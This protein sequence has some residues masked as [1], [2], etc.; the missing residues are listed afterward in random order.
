MT[1]RT[2]KPKRAVAP[3]ILIPAALFLLPLVP[4]LAYFL[5]S[6]LGDFY[7][8]TAVDHRI[9]YFAAVGQNFSFFRTMFDGVDWYR[10]ITLDARSA[11]PELPSLVI[12]GLVVMALSLPIFLLSRHARRPGRYAV[13]CIVLGMV[14]FALFP[15]FR[16]LNRP[17][18]F[19]VLTPIFT[20]CCITATVSFLSFCA[21]RFKRYATILRIS[22]SIGLTLILVVSVRHGIGLL[23]RIES[24]KGAC[25]T[26]M[27]LYDA[28]G[29]VRASNVRTIYAVNYSLAFP[30]FVLSKGTIHVEDITWSELTPEKIE[31]LFGKIKTNSE[32]GI[33]CRYCGNK[34][35]DPNWTHWLNREP[36]IFDFMKRLEI[37]DS[38]L[39]VLHFRDDR[40]TE[41]VLI[42]RTGDKKGRA[43]TEKQAGR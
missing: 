28:Y 29:A 11:I 10:R 20:A 42:T 14:S 8:M 7:S 18:H 3:F 30:I 12:L 40:Q 9:P 2:S 31:E 35:W 1:A 39:D 6:G 13:L 22:F 17:W 33:V 16:G 43:V 36:Q 34:D 5:R 26:S 23:E 41:Y 25:I 38:T 4:H 32:A 19:Y 21:D 37:G 27:A 24:N 15:A